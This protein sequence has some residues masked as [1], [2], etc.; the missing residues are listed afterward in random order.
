MSGVLVTCASAPAGVDLCRALALRMP[1]LACSPEPATAMARL[2][3]SGVRYLQLDLSHSR[4][5]RA[6]LFGPALDAHVEA[7]VHAPACDGRRPHAAADTL[8]ELLHLCDRHP[9]IR[10][11]V[12]IGT[13]DVYRT[14]PGDPALI[15]E[16][17]PLE[18]DPTAPSSVRDLVEADQAACAH[19]ATSRLR[20][21]VLRCAELFAPGAEG[22]LQ[23]W[24]RSEPCLR[25]LGFD[26]MVNLIGAEDLVRAVTLALRAQLAGVFNVAGADTLP[27]TALA[28]KAGRRCV[29]LPGWLVSA[30]YR[31][32]AVA[33]PSFDYQTN[34]TRF[35][36]GSVL[37][38]RAALA[39]FG[40]QP[41]TPLRWEKSNLSSPPAVSEVAL[42]GAEKARRRRGSVLE[43]KA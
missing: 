31:V 29:P 8:R 36:F 42:N 17:H 32:R 14:G 15:D 39:A 37:C 22:P 41:R 35:H 13:A 33:G 1:V 43:A 21:T 6:L 19:I 23:R 2:A 27:I 26:P 16:E 20:V 24:L 25:P 3:E 18:T 30:A 28:A 38:G 34:R 12:Y 4:N 5:R 11:F 9:T 10:R 7:V 40:Y